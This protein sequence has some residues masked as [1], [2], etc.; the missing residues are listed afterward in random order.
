[1]FFKSVNCGFRLN[2]KTNN[3]F[4][5]V[6]P[7]FSLN[8]SCQHF[9]SVI[10]WLRWIDLDTKSRRNFPESPHRLNGLQVINDP[11]ANF[12]RCLDRSWSHGHLWLP[13]THW[14]ILRE[15]PE[16][17]QNTSVSC[18][19]SCGMASLQLFFCFARFSPLYRRKG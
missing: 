13:T 6:D 4:C 9:F 3:P 8:P 5:H 18:A 14:N 15:A 19:R 17:K 1:M 16:N 10:I 11:T 2:S 7:V 12:M